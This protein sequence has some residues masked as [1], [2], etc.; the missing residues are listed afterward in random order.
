[1]GSNP[2]LSATIRAVTVPQF[3]ASRIHCLSTEATLAWLG[4]AMSADL[5]DRVFVSYH[6]HWDIA[7][8]VDHYLNAR[9]VR[10]TDVARASLGRCLEAYTGRRPYAKADLDYY[11]DANW[12]RPR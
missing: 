11:L 12:R 2:T 9:R 3:Q 8:Y 1:M 7:S 6:E 10:P 4:A 5:L